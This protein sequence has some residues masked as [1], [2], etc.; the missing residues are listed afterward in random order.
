MDDDVVTTASQAYSAYVKKNLPLVDDVAPKQFQQEA[1]KAYA[2]VLGGEAL[3]KSK[4]PGDAEAKIKMHI[5]TAQKAASAIAAAT[6]NPKDVQGE[7]FYLQTQDILFPYLD[8]LEGQSI[9]GDEYGI[10]TKLTQKFEDSFMQ[11]MRALNNLDPDEITRVTEFMRE[12]VTFIEKIVENKLAYVTQDGSVYFDIAAFEAA[13]NPYARLE[14]WNRGDLSLVADGEG[15]LTQKMTEKRSQADFALWK[16][17]RAGEPRW[18]SPWGYGRPGWHIECSA[19]A[20]GKLGRQMDIHS[21]GIDLAFPHHDNELAQ[22]EAYWNTEHVHDQ[23]VNYF[24]HMG[25][26]SIQG[27]KMAKSLKNFTTIKEALSR[28]DW[29]PR[30]LRIV[31]LLGTWNDGIEITPDLVKEGS[32][33]EEK[34]NNFFLGAKDLLSKQSKASGNDKSLVGALNS[35]RA[36]AY[37]ALCDSFNTSEVLNVIS[38]LITKYNN[39][40]KE[41]VKLEDVHAVATWIT[42]ILNTF[43]LNGAA[44]PDAP[45]IGWQGIDIPEHAKPYVTSIS[46]IRDTL[47]QEAKSKTGVSHERLEKVAGAAN[48]DGSVSNAAKPYAKALTDVKSQVKSL[49]GSDDP[50]KAI[51]ALCDEIRDVKLFDLGIYLEDRESGPALVRPLTREVKQRVLQGR[52]DKVAEAQRKQQEREKREK[53]ALEKAEKGKVRPQDMF[54]TPEFSAWD[55]DG[56]PTKDVGGEDLAK[57]RAKKLRKDWERQKKAHEAWLA[58]QSNR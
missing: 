53:E 40:D 8:S 34:V 30:S 50:S 56:V 27:A 5:R 55:V 35:A 39:S 41:V 11:D 43:G 16:A 24:L 52:E 49:E 23:W 25:H 48:N 58:T 4:K 47:R 12:I 3:D 2:A 31:F 18:P 19:M 45:E 22:S 14:P 51:L 20:S 38:R 28:G 29:T 10:F 6:A 36:S 46:I 37:D 32:A 42:S 57:S 33:F 1:S 44:G 54:Q 7:D 17:S 26:L 15:S 13:G 21:G 9:G